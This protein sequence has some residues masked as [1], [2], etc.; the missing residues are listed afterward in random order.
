M[1]AVATGMR[2]I[3][4]SRWLM[5]VLVGSLALNLIVVG[6]A[7]SLV[8]RSYFGSHEPLGRRVISSVIGYSSTLAPERRKELERLTKEERENYRPLRR[9]LLDA[10]EEVNK[11]LIAQPFDEARFLAAQA[12]LAEADRRS[13]E[14]SL[15]LQVALSL[16]FTPEERLGYLRWREERRPQN[17]LDT[18]EQ[19]AGGP[20]R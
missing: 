1:T 7:G 5:P 12:R 3:R 20:Q 17:P 19:P 4:S 13:R 8:W 16:H 18:P 14:A 11:A 2:D 6:A 10:R 9:A 15:K